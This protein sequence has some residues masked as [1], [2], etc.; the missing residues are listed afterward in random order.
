MK[1]QEIEK[2]G[3]KFEENILDATKGFEKVITDKEEIK[4]L[5]LTTLTIAAETAIAKVRGFDFGVF[6]VF[7][8]VNLIAAYMWLLKKC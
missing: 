3:Q 6:S 2:L 1:T 5:P 7:F 4:G 8:V